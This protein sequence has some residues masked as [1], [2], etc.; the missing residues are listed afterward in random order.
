[1]T[2]S[3]LACKGTPADGIDGR[4]RCRRNVDCDEERRKVLGRRIS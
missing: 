2:A 1:M 4:A 3:D